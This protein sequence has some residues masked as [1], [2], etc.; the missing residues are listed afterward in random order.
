[1]LV[2]A[3]T[4]TRP[5]RVSVRAGEKLRSVFTQVDWGN[6]TGRPLPVLVRKPVPIIVEVN[7]NAAGRGRSESIVPG[8]PHSTQTGNYTS[9]D[10]DLQFTSTHLQLVFRSEAIRDVHN[11]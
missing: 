6:G 1:M 10:T 11:V 8:R 9:D 4:A 7:E 5:H 3:A 2:P